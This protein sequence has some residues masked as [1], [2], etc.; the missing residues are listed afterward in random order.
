MSQTPHVFIPTLSGAARL[1]RTLDALGPSWRSRCTI[2]DNASQDGTAP[3]LAERYPE[4][5]SLRLPGN[6]GFGGALN[7]AIRARDFDVAIVLND[8][9]VCGAHALE[10]LAAAFAD[11]SVGMAAGVLIQEGSGRIDTAGL[12]CDPSL[13][14][15]DLLKGQPP[16]SLPST[17]ELPGLIG[18]SGGLAA[19]RRA[20][21]EQVGWFDSGFFAYFED[22]DLAFRLRAAGWAGRLVP[23]AQALHT[24]SATLGWRSRRK[25]EIVGRSRG[26]MLAKYGVLRRGRALP[27]LALEVLACVAL[28]LEHR[29]LAPWRSRLEGYRACEV[30]HSYPARAPMAARSPFAT[31]AAR[32]ARRY[33]PAP[34]SS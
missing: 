30:R 16:A 23:E 5:E 13:A 7:A 10:R 18:P 3:L 15:V 33:R 2:I 19:Y 29:S 21:L 24:G 27:W 32:L 20:A 31:V 17:S 6:A 9:V 14:S 26:R 11:P 1:P 4:V 22:L 34:E 25:V 28:T 8:D 12:S